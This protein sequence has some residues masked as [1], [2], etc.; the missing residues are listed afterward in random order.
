MKKLAL[1]ISFAFAASLLAGCASG[2]DTAASSSEAAASSSEVAASS[3]SEAATSS[4][5]EAATSSSSEAATSSS[6][7]AAEGEALTTAV[8]DYWANFPAEGN[9]Q[10]PADEIFKKMDAGEDILILD[11]RAP[12]DYAEA[13]L[14]GAV[15]IPYAKVGENLEALPDDKPIW[16]NCYTG[17]TS[18]QTTALLSFA[19]KDAHNIQGGWMRG[20]SKAEGFENYTDNV[21]VT[22]ADAGIS[23]TYPVDAEIASA[24]QAYYTEASTDE[25]HPSFNFDP[26]ELKEL[27]EAGDDTYTILSVR[28][29]EDYAQEHIPGAI[30][31]PFGKGMQASFGDIPTDKPVVVYCYTGN[32]S[33]QVVPSLRMLGYEAYN[34]SGGW[35]KATEGD[36]EGFGWIKDG[37]G[38]YPVEGELAQA[39]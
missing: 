24:I 18:S 28:Q 22:L 16:I 29:A 37:A 26:A 10:L 6:S 31:I 38:N 25:A 13:H 17:Q 19:G 12:E 7:E 4:S 9:N 30:N 23:G 20:I 21:E 1:I 36:V 34:L 27:V 15:N 2:G 5:S 11:I 33:S 8:M 32:T 3:S 14:K 35:G 39:A